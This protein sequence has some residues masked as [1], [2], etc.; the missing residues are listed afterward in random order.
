M[1]QNE[2]R[3][4]VD[5]LNHYSRLYYTM[6][7]PEIP[8]DEYDRLMRQLK[9]A[10]EAHPE[11]ITSDSPTQRV[12]DA[13]YTTFD[14][15]THTVQ[16]GSLQDVFSEEE[17]WAFH[18]RCLQVE[19]HPSYTV[20]PKI[21]GLSV[22]LEYRDGLFVRGST[23]GNGLVGEDVTMNLA[24]IQDIPKRLSRPLPYLEVRG[25]VYMPLTVFKE[26]VTRQIE[27]EEEPFKNP[28]NAAAGGLRQKDPRVTAARRLSIFVF[29]IQQ[30]EGETVTTHAEGL[31]L[32]RSLGFKVIP[33]FP[34]YTD[35]A[36]VIE[37][38]HGIDQR[39]HENDF[40][41]D[42]AVVKINNLALRETMGSTVKFPRWAVAFKYPPEE[43]ET[44]LR[45]IEIQVGRT[46]AL[47]P[48]A[49]FDSVTLAGTSV[50]RATLHNQDFITEKDIRI[51]D[52][53]LVRKAGEIIPEVLKVVRHGDG[54]PFLIPSHCPVCGSETVR[55]EDEAV[56]R[57]INPECPAT[58]KRSIV[59]FAS[60]NAMDI[61]GLGPAMV[62]LLV[63]NGLIH[64]VADLYELSPEQ[65]TGFERVGEISAANLTTAIAASKERGLARL[66]F[67]LG[68]RN[69]GEKAAQLIAAHFGSMEKLL[70]ATKDDI[71]QK[72][73]NIIPGVGEVIA[74]S[75]L[76]YFGREET[77]K[78]AAHFERVGVKMTED[79]VEKGTVLSGL[80]FVLTG[81]L[82]SLTRKQAADLIEQNGGK[83]TSSVSKKTSYLLA[84]EDA[85]SKLT[86][87]QQL[88]ITILSEQE[89]LEMIPSDGQPS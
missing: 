50:S 81:T 9:E 60:R 62:D 67:G 14:K 1:Q 11:W 12:G 61:E 74:D 7:N 38:I 34:V 10:E 5:R 66:L 84:G 51:G 18:N 56:I 59:H 47:T 70:N 83:V 69:V 80:T 28:R 79:V 52:T 64:S 30:I 73:E 71:W 16:M 23:R 20:E 77:R 48:T 41:I 4:L 57:C 29:N 78:L 76:E 88:G 2:Y 75:L 37:D 33:E 89:F 17:L 87:A 40:D 68:I 58:I 3:Q 72:K 82:P 53:I 32:L 22:S 6:D 42:G 86:K 15:V 13:I 65:L 46:G 55:D 54:E 31:E 21:D 85:G 35:F 25:E 43:K 49:V 63:D 26:L 39:R 8:D 36:D 24:T 27:N 19:E 44:V 45:N